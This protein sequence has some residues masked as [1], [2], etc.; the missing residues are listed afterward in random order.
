VPANGW[1]LGTWGMGTVLGEVVGATV[2]GGV[3][4]AT[5]LAI[6]LS[7]SGGTLG[8]VTAARGLLLPGSDGGPGAGLGDPGRGNVG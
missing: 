3:A 5:L 8:S 4:D 1:L 7:R 2:L 6:S